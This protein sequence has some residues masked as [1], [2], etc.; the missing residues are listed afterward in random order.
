MPLTEA[1]IERYSRHILLPSVGGA[2][3][4]RLLA[5]AVLLAVGRE[6]AGAAAVAAVYL[7]AAGV[8]R[9]GWAIEPG[10]PPARGAEPGSLAGLLALYD[11]E[12][13]EASVAALNPD[14]ALVRVG[15]EDPSFGEFDLL[16]ILGEG[17]F[18]RRWARRYRA[19]GK[20]VLRGM[21]RGWSGAVRSGEEAQEMEISGIEPAAGE[22]PLPPAPPE[23][24][25]GAALAASAL[26][27]LLRRE[28]KDMVG[29]T[30]QAR[31]GFA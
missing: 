10:A 17:E 29:S 26:R 20:A 15:E 3:Q 21:R 30:M 12:G 2:G 25:L 9:L 18:L 8:G 27:V 31:F 16:A 22:E 23:G 19:L 13:P 6:D 11:A 4:R 24:M 1:Q 5:S 28:E 14:V 7:A